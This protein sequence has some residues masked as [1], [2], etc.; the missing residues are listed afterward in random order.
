MNS[1]NDSGTFHIHDCF[2]DNFS[3][4]SCKYK[5][6]LSG[7]GQKKFSLSGTD[8]DDGIV[9]ISAN[10][11]PAAPPKNPTGFVN[12]LKDSGKTV[13]RDEP[14][15]PPPPRPAACTEFPSQ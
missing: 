11:E 2:S 10:R 1:L 5:F 14:A 9:R 3:V 13:F 4:C 6:S 8:K 15:E 7:A 12:P